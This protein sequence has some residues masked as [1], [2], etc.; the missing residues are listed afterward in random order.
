MPIIYDIMGFFI[1][2]TTLDDYPLMDNKIVLE[3]IAIFYCDCERTYDFI[4][5]T[6]PEVL[7]KKMVSSKIIAY[8]NAIYKGYKILDEYHSLIGKNFR[9][10][11][12]CK[13]TFINDNLMVSMPSTGFYRFLLILSCIPDMFLKMSDDCVLLKRSTLS[14]IIEFEKQDIKKKFKQP[15][16]ENINTYIMIDK[17]TGYYKIGQSINITKREKTLQAERPTIHLLYSCGKNIE[18]SLHAKYKEF[19]VRGEWFN[20]TP[21]VLL[22]IVNEGGFVEAKLESTPIYKNNENNMFQQREEENT[23]KQL[24]S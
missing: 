9:T 11:K 8:A 19:R 20:L 10:Y 18:R 21:E 23:I 6:Y 15:T 12:E 16:R 3:T 5:K 24:K 7:E 2:M 17:N 22:E 1:F 4:T 13:F 14:A